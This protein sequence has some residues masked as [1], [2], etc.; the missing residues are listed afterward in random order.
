MPFP[1]RSLPFGCTCTWQEQYQA[2]GN[3]YLDLV[4]EVALGLCASDL[5]WLF[6]FAKEKRHQAQQRLMTAPVRI[7]ENY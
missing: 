1:L 3:S 5:K 4:S 2:P 7:A 6:I